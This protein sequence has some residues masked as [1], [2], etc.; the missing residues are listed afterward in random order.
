MFMKIAKLGVTVATVAAVAF[1]AASL[2][3]AQESKPSGTLMQ[4]RQGAMGTEKGSQKPA[5]QSGDLSGKGAPTAEDEAKAA[6]GGATTGGS[7]QFGP[8]G[9]EGQDG[10]SLP[11][12]RQG[13]IGTQERPP[14]P[15]PQGG[16]NKQ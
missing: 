12:M 5:E 15:V 16:A 13:T 2:A 1:G 10:N 3:S 11:A 8:K 14:E 4:E 6:T 7:L 9:Q